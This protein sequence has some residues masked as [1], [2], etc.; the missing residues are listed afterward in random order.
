MLLNQL[1]V[2]CSFNW[3]SELL[4]MFER[5]IE[6]FPNKTIIDDN[7]GID[8]SI[9][10]NNVTLFINNKKFHYNMIGYELL[11]EVSKKVLKPKKIDVIIDYPHIRMPESFFEEH[12][13][14][15]PTRLAV[16]T[17][18]PSSKISPKNFNQFF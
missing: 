5:Q 16:W 14:K 7:I 2:E 12:E 8:Y 4:N 1:R 10:L 6:I 11:L 9:G 18:T 15:M 13:L 17:Y 3:E